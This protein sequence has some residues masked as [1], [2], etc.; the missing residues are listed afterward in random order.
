[1][2]REI[3]YRG[4][5]EDTNHIVEGVYWKDAEGNHRITYRNDK[6]NFVF[7]H[8]IKPESLSE[9]IGIKDKNGVKI[10]SGDKVKRKAVNSSA[11]GRGEYLIKWNDEYAM[12]GLW[13]EKSE[14][15]ATDYH[16][17]FYKIIPKN[18]EVV[19]NIYVVS[20]EKLMDSPI[21]GAMVNGLSGEINKQIVEDMIALGDTK[22]LKFYELPT[23]SDLEFEI[24][25]EFIGQ[26]D[27]LKNKT[28]DRTSV[29]TVYDPT[30]EHLSLMNVTHY[31]KKI[32]VDDENHKIIGKI[33]L[34]QTHQGRKVQSD[35][36][37]GLIDILVIPVVY[38]DGVSVKIVERFDIKQIIRN[39]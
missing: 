31:V 4:V 36:S 2:Y 32:D 20:D 12:F 15:F 7:N 16:N 25:W 27:V 10:F 5:S 24:P 37:K 33:K 29:G 14:K 39:S 6:E 8:I 13:S 30:R 17:R 23:N 19:G 18:T 35:F 22:P 9:Y 3:L 1:M 34:L 21:I 11:G 38:S 28:M 26:I